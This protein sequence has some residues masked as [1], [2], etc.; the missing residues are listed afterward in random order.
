MRFWDSSALLTLSAGQPQAPSLQPV[1]DDDPKTAIWWGT[2]VEMVSGACR[3]R[4]EGRFDEAGFQDLLAGIDQT[5]RE[6][7]EVDPSEKLREEAVRLIKV[8]E[9]RAGDAL[10]LAA[11]LEWAGRNPRGAG[12]VCMDKRLREAAAKEGF[13]VLPKS[14]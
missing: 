7:D 3:L 9:L 10:Q 8:H 6:A 11:A 5:C 2:R 1:M 14:K 4:R 13:S 12:F